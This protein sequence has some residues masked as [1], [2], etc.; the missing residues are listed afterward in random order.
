MSRVIQYQRRALEKVIDQ[1]SSFTIEAGQIYIL[2]NSVVFLAGLSEGVGTCSDMHGVYVAV[3]TKDPAD[4]SRIRFLDPN[5]KLECG[6]AVLLRERRRD[7]FN[8]DIHPSLIENCL[9]V[10]GLCVLHNV[11]KFKSIF[12]KQN[13]KSSLYVDLV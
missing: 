11:P 7:E 3:F 4:Q 5:H 9:A 6:G 13:G 1:S 12:F 8:P 10:E 2:N